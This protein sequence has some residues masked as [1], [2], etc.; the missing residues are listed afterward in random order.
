[1]ESQQGQ[2]APESRD[3]ILAAVGRRRARIY[4]MV[5]GVLDR[6]EDVARWK[7]LYYP[8]IETEAFL[9]I[10]RDLL[11]GIDEVPYRIWE[12][13]VEILEATLRR[14][15]RALPETAIH[16]V[17]KQAVVELLDA[18]AVVGASAEAKGLARRAVDELPPEVVGPAL[19]QVL[20]WLI[21]RG[22]DEA[23]EISGE[24]P[25]GAVAGL[26][27][28]ILD[29]AMQKIL[30][31][32][33][34]YFDGI[35]A[36]TADEVEKLRARVALFEE[37]AGKALTAEDRLF[38]CELAADLKGRY[39]SA[40]MG[41]VANLVAEGHWSG[42]EIEP[43]L[44]PE[45]AEEFDRNELLVATLKEVLAG[46]ER[47]PEDV[48]LV[49]LVADWDQ[50]RR[51]DCYA[52]THLYGF[53]GNVGKLL[54][55]SSRRALYSGDYHQIQQR[56]GRLSARVTAL[57][58]LHNKTWEERQEGDSSVQDC[59]PQMVEKAIQLAAILD[60]ELLKQI[61]GAERVQLLLDIVSIEGGKRQGEVPP[62]S[63]S[64][65]ARVPKLMMPVIPLLHDEDLKTFLELLLGSVLKRASFTLTRRRAAAAA[66]VPVAAPV[67]EPAQEAPA[68]PEP[69]PEAAP[70]SALDSWLEPPPLETLT[71]AEEPSAEAIA[72][73]RSAAK[74]AALEKLHE[75]LRE[76]LSPTHQHRR[77]FDLVHR[78]LRRKRMIPPAML[79]SLVP[80]VDDLNDKL[81]PLL[82]TAAS[83]AAVPI[84][85][86]SELTQYCRALKRRDL[87]PR[88]LKTE[89]TRNM[90]G[91]LRLLDDLEAAARE[92]ID[93]AR[94][95]PGG[96][97]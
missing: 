16:A 42:A 83:H 25:D 79:H 57:N 50:G 17:A 64:L 89:V 75:H 51:V 27:A 93:N 92:A 53:L 52:L 65:R 30:G 33:Q 54:K 39:T 80:F 88:E 36:M 90:E 45:K 31:N 62:Q 68:A 71:P 34:L 85:Y 32:L 15:V 40:M 12:L 23:E 37:G 46:I 61:I 41:A 66:A 49:A 28:E 8:P 21:A 77:S 63:A 18:E 56:E 81:V 78:L 69:V 86:Q 97:Q 70:V 2:P 35:H 87:G 14:Y 38:T 67:Q 91:L 47:L 10:Q 74:L 95:L 58:M 1:M 7:D 43:I 59:Y 6:M 5:R 44:F 3:E 82:A 55:E 48:P 26:P 84:T 4:H 94:R 29:A 96:Y 13:H 19:K 76:A 22:D 73:Q 9:G 24:P 60:V 11:A 20:C 72:E